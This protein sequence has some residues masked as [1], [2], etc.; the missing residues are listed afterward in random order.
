MATSGPEGA[1]KIR[2]GSY[3]VVVSDLVMN[4]LD[5]MGILKTARESSPESEVILVTGHASIPKAVEAMQ[6][7]AFNFLEIGRAHV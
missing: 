7:G 2:Q 1:E 5:G 4:D 3:D 6:E